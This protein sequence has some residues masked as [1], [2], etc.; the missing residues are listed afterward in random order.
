MSKVHA[1]D[2]SLTNTSQHTH[3]TNDNG[4]FHFQRATMELQDTPLPPFKMC[5]LYDP[6]GHRQ[7]KNLQRA[8]GT[9]RVHVT[10]LFNWMKVK[11]ICGGWALLVEGVFSDHS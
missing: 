1:M 2:I 6:Q 5:L 4:A 8:Y 7:L 10:V 9:N 11:T 3:H